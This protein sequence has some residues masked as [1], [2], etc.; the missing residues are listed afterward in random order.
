MNFQDYDDQARSTMI[1]PGQKMLEGLA[2][3]A[4]GLGGEAGETI[5]IIKKIMRANSNWATAPSY[6]FINEAKREEIIAELGDVLW[7]LS[8]VARELGV[9]LNLVAMR[10]IEKLRLRHNKI[11]S[12]AAPVTGEHQI[13]QGEPTPPSKEPAQAREFWR[14][15]DE[16]RKGSHQAEPSNTIRSTDLDG[17]WYESRRGF[18]ETKHPQDNSPTAGEQRVAQ[19]QAAPELSSAV[20]G[21]RKSPKKAGKR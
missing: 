6:M 8:A 17:Y 16:A 5:D 11:G 20:D 13:T 15:Y 9:S 10:N 14:K 21:T 19:T 7:Y 12:K 1:Y 4:L 2:Y 18:P 3:T